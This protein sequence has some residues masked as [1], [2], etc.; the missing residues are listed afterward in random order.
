MPDGNFMDRFMCHAAL[1]PGV[2]R[3]W[4][5]IL[6]QGPTT[7]KLRVKPMQTASLHG[8]NIHGYTPAQHGVAL[9]H[10]RL[11]ARGHHG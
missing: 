10:A 4:L 7:V 2:F 6:L 1:Q 5:R 9:Y 11:L 3:V 8:K